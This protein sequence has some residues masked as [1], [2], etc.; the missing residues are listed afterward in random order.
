MWGTVVE[1]HILRWNSTENRKGRMLSTIR[2]HWLRAAVGLK[3]E[4]KTAM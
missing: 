4:A 2:S 3:G 1:L